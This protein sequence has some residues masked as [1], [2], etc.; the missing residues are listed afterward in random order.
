MK[1]FLI[2]HTKPDIPGN[3]C[4]G[5]SDLNVLP[6]FKSELKEVHS[7]LNEIKYS[8]V[9]S[10]PLKRCQELARTLVSD[11]EGIIL[12]DRLMEFNFGDWEMKSWDEIETTP[13]ADNWFADY[14]KTPVPGGESFIQLLERVQNFIDDLKVNIRDENVIIA[15]HLGV[16]RAFFVIINQIDAKEAFNLNVAYGELCEMELKI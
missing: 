14:I 9:F 4:Y 11:G 12:D 10:S 1:L 5:Q 8:Q 3:I 6:S 7:L 2:R 16:I 13:E 15:T